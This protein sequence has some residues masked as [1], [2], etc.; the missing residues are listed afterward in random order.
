MAKA[1]V[2]EETSKNS[3]GRISTTFRPAGGKMNRSIRRRSWSRHIAAFA[4]S[5][6]GF[7]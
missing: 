3:S 4:D 1:P 6:A 7:S 2:S 5:S